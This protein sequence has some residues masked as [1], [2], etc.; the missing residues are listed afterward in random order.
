MFEKTLPVIEKTQNHA[1]TKRG[2]NFILSLFF[3]FDRTLQKGTSN[4][5][6]EIKIN[7]KNYIKKAPWEQNQ[8]PVYGEAEKHLQWLS[9]M[10][11]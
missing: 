3:F 1:C 9:T 7:T 10:Q 11:I 5:E 8:F 6:N 2:E 4:D